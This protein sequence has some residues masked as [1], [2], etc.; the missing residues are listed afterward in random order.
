MGIGHVP[1]IMKLWPNDQKPFIAAILKVPP[2]SLTSKVVRLTFRVT[3]LT[4]GGYL[5]YKFVPVPKM[6]KENSHLVIQ[7]ILMSVKG[8]SNFKYALH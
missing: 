2:P 5:V 7:R 8:S 3:L 6:L 1:G 4:F